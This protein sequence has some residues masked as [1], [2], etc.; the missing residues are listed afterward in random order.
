MISKY[1][2]AFVLLLHLII[3]KSEPS[4]PLVGIY[5]DTLIRACNFLSYNKR[6]TPGSLA[7]YAK[8]QTT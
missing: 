3:A 6:I 5:L 7:I 8:K 1:V 4:S 2:I